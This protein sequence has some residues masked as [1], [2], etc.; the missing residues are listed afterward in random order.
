MIARGLCT[1]RDFE[2]TNDNRSYHI[3]SDK[4]YRVLSFKPK[5]S[6]EDAVIDLKN[7]FEKKLLND[8]LNN[9]E[10]FNIKKMQFLNLK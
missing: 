1:A 7:A 6:I 3:S 5:K 2:K 4:I 10:Y 9:I 8:P